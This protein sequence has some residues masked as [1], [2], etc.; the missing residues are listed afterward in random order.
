MNKQEKLHYWKEKFEKASAAYAGEIAAFDEREALYR[1]DRSIRRIISGDV[2]KRTPH[3]RNIAAEVVEAQIDPVIPS[4][5]VTA[6]RE[7]DAHLAKAIE[8]MLSCELSRLPFEVIND[9][10]ERTVPIQGSGFF[11]VEWDSADNTHHKAGDVSVSF[12]HPRQVIPQPGV[13]TGIGDMDYVFL[14]LPQTKA[15]LGR[16]YSADLENESGESENDD[17]VTQT[18]VYY[19]NENGSVGYFSWVGDTVLCDMEDYQARAVTRC[20]KC[21]APKLAGSRKCD[22]GSAEFE[23]A[24]EEYEEHSGIRVAYYK[25]DI[26]PIIQQKNISV[27]KSFLG[28]SDIDKIS[29]QQNTV[30]RVEAKIIDKLLKAGSYITLP[31]SASIRADGED[32]K[33][34]RPGSPQDKDMISVYTLEGDISQDLAYLDKIYEE[35]KDAIG[36]T[37]S[38]L[39]KTDSTAVSG[40]AK[41]IAANQAAG[42]FESKKIQKYAAYAALFEAIFKFKLA[43][44]DEPRSVVAKNSPDTGKYDIFDRYDFLMS[45]EAGELYWNDDF[46]FSC[47]DTSSLA[48]NRELMWEET[49]NNFSSGAYGDPGSSDAL[50]LFWS[51]MSELHYPGAAGT[52]QQIEENARLNKEKAV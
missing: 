43:Y 40:K 22:C 41:Q 34:I 39:G 32:M 46:L 14:L 17:I 52:K 2:K 38:Y 1:G 24:G 37:D 30:N 33:I 13:Y 49:R 10:M 6:M 9:M 23:T 12:L 5:V 47:D 25:P 11:L 4:P 20:R 3:V 8:N 7:K 44:A 26:I 35:A 29:D 45:D 48:A 42:R 18:A 16:K 21:G 19:R 27:Y 51:K 36:I 28:E 50:I 31:D 15:A